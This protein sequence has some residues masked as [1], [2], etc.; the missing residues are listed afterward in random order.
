MAVKI[1]IGKSAK[2]IAVLAI[3][4]APP[5]KIIP[6][7]ED[8]GTSQLFIGPILRRKRC[9]TINPTK[10]IMP[11]KDTAPAVSKA[12]TQIAIKRRRG[13]FRPTYLAL[14]SPK[15]VSPV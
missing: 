13:T 9:G 8:K 5:T 14:F 2:C 12:V 15:P 11:A 7:I 4:S 1:P 3:R 6:P 10:V